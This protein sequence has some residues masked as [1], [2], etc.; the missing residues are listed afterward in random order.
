MVKN[1]KGIKAFSIICYLLSLAAVGYFV[2]VMV[3]TNGDFGLN[4]GFNIGLIVAA[5]MFSI[6]GVVLNPPKVLNSKSLNLT[7]GLVLFGLSGVALAFLIYNIATGFAWE[8]AL[9]C[10]AIIIS[11]LFFG[12]ILLKIAKQDI[13]V[14]ARIKAEQKA[15]DEKKAQER[16]SLTACPYCG[17]RL[18]PTNEVCPNCKSKL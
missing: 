7:S 10:A 4:I 14:D 18:Q 5:V 16:A 1:S 15:L 6:V 8:T 13:N 9:I 12:T 17:C 2:Y 11:G 3:K